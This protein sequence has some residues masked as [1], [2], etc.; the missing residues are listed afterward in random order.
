MHVEE[1]RKEAGVYEKHESEKIWASVAKRLT[2]EKTIEKVEQV[3]EGVCMNKN[4][5]RK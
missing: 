5:I 1:E 4:E 2:H 3:E